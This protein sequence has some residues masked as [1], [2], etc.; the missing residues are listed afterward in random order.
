MSE[1]IK[2][3]KKEEKK[4]ELKSQNGIEEENQLEAVT[5]LL[6]EQL[7]IKDR[8]WYLTTYKTCFV[9][10][11]AVSLLVSSGVAKTR[12]QA[13]ELGNLMLAAN[14]FRHVTKDHNFKDD[15]LYYR[16]AMDEVSHG[17]KEKNEETSQDWSWGDLVPGLFRSEQRINLQ[18]K[19]KDLSL[20]VGNAKLT[21]NDTFGVWPIDKYN[22]E[23]LDNV[24]PVKWIFLR[25]K[26]KYNI[27]ILIRFFFN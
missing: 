15:N 8:K 25:T 6:R 16:F 9:G 26:G 19:V 5:K 27:G 3:E 23:L 17:E 11:E 24:H 21:E 22:Q 10:S 1:E 7:E 12:E 20:E 18:A 14:V 2:E 4:E 13:V